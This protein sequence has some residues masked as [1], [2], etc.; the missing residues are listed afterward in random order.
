MSDVVLYKY[1]S[2]DRTASV[3]GVPNRDITREEFNSWGAAQKRAVAGSPL[4]K[5]V[6]QMRQEKKTVVAPAVR[7][8]GEG[9]T[10]E[11]GSLAEENA[12]ATTLQGEKKK[13]K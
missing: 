13:E 8:S 10:E 7:D 6:R 2:D 1:I 12:A 11:S 3:A 5:K 4:H 9:K